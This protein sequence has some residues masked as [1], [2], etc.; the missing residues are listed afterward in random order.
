MPAEP[1]PQ[2]SSQATMELE[3][4]LPDQSAQNGR[5]GRILVSK[6]IDAMIEAI[7]ESAR[8]GKTEGAERSKQES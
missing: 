7:A 3:F 5:L 8:K 1:Q 2:T 6:D 4:S